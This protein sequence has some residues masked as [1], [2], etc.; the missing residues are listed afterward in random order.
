MLENSSK[1]LVNQW[2]KPFFASCLP[3]HQGAKRLSDAVVKTSSGSLYTPQNLSCFPFQLQNQGD[4]V[5]SQ[6]PQGLLS[7]LS[8]LV[9]LGIFTLLANPLWRKS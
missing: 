6:L 9:S 4:V 2:T 5:E 8:N 1:F 3:V 7:E